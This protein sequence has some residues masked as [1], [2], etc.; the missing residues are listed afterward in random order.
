MREKEE[1]LEKRSEQGGKGVC[2]WCE[3]VL[4]LT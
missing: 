1:W 3:S 4:L 2:R